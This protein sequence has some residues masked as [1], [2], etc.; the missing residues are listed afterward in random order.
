MKACGQLQTPDT[1]SPKKNAPDTHL[2]GGGV[3]SRISL[4]IVTKRKIPA[5]AGNLMLVV[6]PAVSHYTG[7]PI[8]ASYVLPVP[9]LN[10]KPDH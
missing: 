7:W 8:L 1:S 10:S 3:G 2:V 4:D 9:G 5:S 6:Q